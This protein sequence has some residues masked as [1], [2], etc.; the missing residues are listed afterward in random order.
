MPILNFSICIGRGENVLGFEVFILWSPADV[1]EWGFIFIGNGAGDVLLL[2]VE[3]LDCSIVTSFIQ[4]YGTCGDVAILWIKLN[5]MNFDF[6][7]TLGEEM[8]DVD[9]GVGDEFDSALGH[10]YSCSFVMGG[11][12]RFLSLISCNN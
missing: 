2:Q 6:G 9:G 3:D 5:R 7:F 4:R 11:T 8:L 10:G 1:G 12:S